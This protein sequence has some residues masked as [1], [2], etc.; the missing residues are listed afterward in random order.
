MG[1]KQNCGFMWSYCSLWQKSW[2]MQSPKWTFITT[3][4]EYHLLTFVLDAS[5]LLFLSSPL[6]LLR[7]IETKLHVEPLWER[8]MK[9]CSWDLGH[10]IKIFTMPIYGKNPLKIFFSGLERSNTVH[11]P[12]NLVWALGTLALPGLFKW[13]QLV[14]LDL[15]WIWKVSNLYQNLNTEKQNFESTKCKFWVQKG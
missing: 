15:F 1:K 6:K 9:V 10:M 4:G 13:W 3:K 11:V 7:V 2:Y 14:Y 8:G 12:W 5:D